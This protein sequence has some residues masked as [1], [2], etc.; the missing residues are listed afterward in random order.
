MA[1]VT[2]SRD[3]VAPAEPPW[4]LGLGSEARLG[5]LGPLSGMGT[6]ALSPGHTNIECKYYFGFI[7]QK[8]EL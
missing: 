3:A 2:C 7:D 1:S 8:L 4:S 5:L 6:T